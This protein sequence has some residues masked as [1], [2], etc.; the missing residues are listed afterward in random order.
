MV[1][2]KAGNPLC[3]IALTVL[4]LSSPVL[5]SAP[6]LANTADQVK[7]LGCSVRSNESQDS[8]IRSIDICLE[9][10]RLTVSQRSDLLTIRRQIAAHSEASLSSSQIAQTLASFQDQIN[11][12]RAE[13]SRLSQEKIASDKA[14]SEREVQLTQTIVGLKAQVAKLS[15][16]PQLVAS[17]PQTSPPEAD[18]DQPDTPPK[19]APKYRPTLTVSGSVNLLLGGVTGP[20]DNL[21][22]NFWNS[23]IVNINRA[24]SNQAVEL[25][26]NSVTGATNLAGGNAFAYY[27]SGQSNRFYPPNGLVPVDSDVAA[28]YS[29][30]SSWT[31][32]KVRFTTL[33]RGGNL[34]ITD[35]GDPNY[36][37]TNPKTL[38]KPGY[39]LAV[40]LKGQPVLPNSGL[41]GLKR[42]VVNYKDV[43]AS[44]FYQSNLGSDITFAGIAMAQSDMQD[45]ID[46]GNASRRLKL[47]NRADDSFTYTVRAGDTI[48]SVAN[49][50]AT[51]AARL[52][53]FNKN[54]SP[55]VSANT[56]LK[57][58][59]KLQIPSVGCVDLCQGLNTVSRGGL[60]ENTTQYDDLL[61]LAVAEY[62]SLTTKQ[63]N[64]SAVLTAAQSFIRSLS[65]STV[66]DS[67]ENEDFNF[68][69]SYTFNNDVKVHFRTSFTG[70][71]LLNMT[72][73]YRNIVPYGERGRFPALNLAYGFAGREGFEATDVAFDRLWW[74]IPVWTD[75]SFW[76][77]TRYKDYDV[78]PVQYGTF[79]PV[80]QQNYFFASGAG[81]A[82][83]VGS[84][85]GL[86]LRNIA[87]NFLGGNLHL[88]GAYL[89]NPFDALNP[90]SNS[91]QQKGIAG[92][93]TRFR[94]PLQLGY[95][96]NDGSIIASLNYVYSRGDTLNAFVGTNLSVNP[97]FY[98]VDSYSQVGATFGWQ[99]TE[100]VSLNLVYNNFMYT[101][102]YDVNVLGVPMAKAGDTARAQSWMAALVFTDFLVDN[103]TSALAIGQVPYIYSNQSA[104]GTNV[105]PLAFEAW[106]NYPLTD[107][108]FIQ[109]AV[110]MVT[111]HDG[112]SSGGT[113]WGSTFRVYLNF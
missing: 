42:P 32:G 105:A 27:K 84:G 70:T 5:A 74:K 66:G 77:G 36:S 75:A 65:G 109:P 1:V 76:I 57:Q 79:Y 90:V 71:D 2:M 60:V 89:A 6:P 83:Y 20:N 63:Q 72:V 30:A 103:S 4:A 37:A 35:K 111:N 15:P 19:E 56:V 106:Y 21:S 13:V 11:Q 80:E 16:T 73:R 58:G 31:G 53:A 100:D 110:F 24:F 17:A 78:L 26:P 10:N 88:G 12:L 45:L 96:S 49:A 104:W 69:R 47:G 33:S 23:S 86:T 62:G 38:D 39:E 29:V 46:L 59:S 44:S 25:M 48:S 41:G 9:S 82:D 8:I 108:V 50:N 34:I 94:A 18:T 97:F 61:N 112:F 43:S 113:D 28:N 99:F 52:I 40:N 3:P 64:N 101:S 92:R 107:R 93:D 51:S 81:L 54:L 102:R 85:V 68:Q 14:F 7:R 67:I 22:T 87:K 98:D 91:Y 55:S 95:T